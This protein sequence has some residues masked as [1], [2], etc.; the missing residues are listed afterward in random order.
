MRKQ[1]GDVV[2]VLPRQWR[3]RRPRLHSRW[4]GSK[5]P[6]R[7]PVLGEDRTIDVERG[8]FKDV[9]GGYDVHIYRIE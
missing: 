5:A 3:T 6:Q 1:D 8:E 2:F 7:P 4:V 9:F